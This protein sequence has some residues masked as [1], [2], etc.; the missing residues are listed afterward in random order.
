MIATAPCPECPA[1]PSSLARLTDQ[2]TLI[3]YAVAKAAGRVVH[4]PSASPPRHRRPAPLT[5]FN[6]RTLDDINAP[7]WLYREL[8]LRQETGRLDT[9]RLRASGAFWP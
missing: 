7:D 8:T 2:L 4:A 3:W 9:L 5:W 1:V 6:R